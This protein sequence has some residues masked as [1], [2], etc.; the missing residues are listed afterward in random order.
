MP[1]KLIATFPDRTALEAIRPDLAVIIPGNVKSGFIVQ[2][3]SVLGLITSGLQLRRRS[4][5][6]TTGTGFGTGSAVGQVVDASVFAA[7]DVL[8]KADGTA[9]GTVLSIQPLATPNTV[10]LTANATNAVATGNGVIATDG[11]QKAVGISDD[12]TDGTADTNVGVY[13]QG[14]MNQSLLEGLDSTAI[15]ELG[16]LST[17]GGIFKF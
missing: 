14:L 13:V 4:R 11:S 6:L 9:I 7:G 1:T 15:S 3:G 16:G 5:T 2:R 8:T 17:V 12:Q 10:T